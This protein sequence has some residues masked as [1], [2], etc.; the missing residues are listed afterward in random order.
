MEPLMGKICLN[1]S[2]PGQFIDAAIFPAAYLFASA[3]LRPQ[4][5]HDPLIEKIVVKL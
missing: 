4:L 1:L 2:S 5:K 3:A